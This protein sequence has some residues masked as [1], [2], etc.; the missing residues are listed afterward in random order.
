MIHL[1]LTVKPTVLQTP[2]TMSGLEVPEF[3]ASYIECKGT[4]ASR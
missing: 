1:R 4:E 3:L 2:G